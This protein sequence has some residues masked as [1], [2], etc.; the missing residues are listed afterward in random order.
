MSFQGKFYPWLIFILSFSLLVS[1]WSHNNERDEANTRIESLAEMQRHTNERLTDTELEISDKQRAIEKLAAEAEELTQQLE[2][3]QALNA[4]KAERLKALEAQLEKAKAEVKKAQDEAALANKQAAARKAER[5]R[6]AA[7]KQQRLTVQAKATASAAAKPVQIVSATPSRSASPK[8]GTTFYV[9]STAYTAYCTGCS[10]VTRTGIDLRANPGL[11]VIAV[12]PRVIPLGSKVYVEGYGHAVAGDT[13][14]AIKGHKIDL[15]MAERKD[16]LKWG[17][18]S[19]Q[20][21]VLN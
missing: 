2:E 6:K 8:A 21:T 17:R 19:V 18:R 4:D 11:K 14:G 1:T 3:Q 16:A 5:K 7:E 12:D 9:E 13:G 15:F 10:G 20:I